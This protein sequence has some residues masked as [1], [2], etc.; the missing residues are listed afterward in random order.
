MFARDLRGLIADFGATASNETTSFYRNMCKTP[1]AQWTLRRAQKSVGQRYHVVS[2]SL[3]RNT[4]QG[5]IGED[6]FTFLRWRPLVIP[7]S[8]LQHCRLALCCMSLGNG[9]G[10]QPYWFTCT[11][12][13][14]CTQPQLTKSE[15]DFQLGFWFATLFMY[16]ESSYRSRVFW[17]FRY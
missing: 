6:L 2:A 7:G 16:V 5:S 9:F 8:P 13:H 15:S 4:R 3:K 17:S 1:L 10:T 14:T 11:Y 12:M